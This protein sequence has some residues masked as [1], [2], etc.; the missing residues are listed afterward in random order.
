MHDRRLPLAEIIRP[1]RRHFLRSALQVSGAA[2]LAASGGAADAVERARSP[3]SGVEASA[4]RVGTGSVG[5]TG[6]ALNVGTNLPLTGARIVATPGGASTATDG[7]GA[8]VLDV[9]P[10][11]YRVSV[12]LD[13]YVGVIRLG[14]QVTSG[15]LPLDLELVPLAS[16][17]GQLQTIYARLVKQA[18]APLV[19]S[20]LATVSA[21]AL[22]GVSLPST[23][24]V[25]YDQANPPYSVQVPLED[26]VKGV[27]PNEMPWSWPAATLQAQA[28]A[29]RSYGVA[30]QLAK[31][32]VYPDTRSQVYDPTQETGPTN[33][34]VGA[35]AGQVMTYNGAVIW[36]YFYSCCNGVTTLNSEDA[37][38]Q[39]PQPSGIY[40]CEPAPWNYVAYCRARPCGGHGASPNSDCGYWGHGV[41][42]CQ[43]GAWARGDE[44]TYQQ[45]L[46]D[47][48]TGI[49]IAGPTPALQ[50]LGPGL[51]QAG[52]PITLVWTGDSTAT[53]QVI[54]SGV[55]S[56]NV[57]AGV[58][59]LP[60]GALPV[61][62]Y[63]WSVAQN[64]ASAPVSATLR[65]VA[66]LHQTFLP[67]VVN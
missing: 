12:S 58:Q 55:N 2:L 46:D 56:W 63:T 51:A 36:A 54:L 17:P 16:S 64:S 33:A 50:P 35:T 42:M 24:T 1:S 57:A 13:G 45:I 3:S 26:Y 29:A 7:R 27:I 14:Q 11:T 60:I 47:Y 32:F 44:A 28:V 20:S 6:R 8:Y 48:Y 52:A 37:L 34:A 39:V 40:G 5:F 66:N 38:K 61:G 15:Y 19:P 18:A 53:T 4:E 25:K 59:S 22:N 23:I 65:V 62:V 21:L 10:G 49:A 9:P 67:S 30:S 43:W 31:G 41:G